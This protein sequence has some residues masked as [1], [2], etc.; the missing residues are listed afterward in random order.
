MPVGRWLA[1][2]TAAD[3]YF[4]CTLH[5]RGE[6]DVHDAN[7][8]DEQRDGGDGDHDVGE[9]GLRPLLLFEE[10]RRNGDGEILDAPV[11]GVQDRV[12]DLGDFDAVGAGFEAHV[13]AVELIL[14]KGA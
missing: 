10:D 11:S 4:A 6:D 8:A 13:D 1:G 5:D 9:D 3:A 12:H 7:A 2:S 14:E